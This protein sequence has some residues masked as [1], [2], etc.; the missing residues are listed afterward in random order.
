MRNNSEQKNASRTKNEHEESDSLWIRMGD[1]RQRA[2][3]NRSHDKKKGG[4]TSSHPSNKWRTADNIAPSKRQGDGANV[5][6]ARKV[7]S[8]ARRQK[9]TKRAH[10]SETISYRRGSAD[11]KTANKRQ[12]WMVRDS[13]KHFGCSC[14]AT[15]I[16]AVTIQKRSN[17]NGQR[18][19]W[20]RERR[21]EPC[22]QCIHSYQDTYSENRF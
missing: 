15:H 13:T 10:G 17:G 1:F 21:T 14:R 20:N 2:E 11:G 7:T 3:C 8:T 6:E 4:R 16:A 5:R 22:K 18:A 12:R 19:V 9:A